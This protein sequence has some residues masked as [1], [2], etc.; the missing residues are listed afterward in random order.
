MK[1]L[2]STLMTKL[3][4]PLSLAETLYLIQINIQ[5]KSEATDFEFGDCQNDCLGRSSMD[6][7]DRPWMIGRG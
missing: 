4:Q 5:T 2:P 6:V 7:D 3:Q 1:S